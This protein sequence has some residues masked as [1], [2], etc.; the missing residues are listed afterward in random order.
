MD[1]RLHVFHFPSPERLGHLDD[2]DAQLGGKLPAAMAR[3]PFF[4]SLSAQDLGKQLGGFDAPIDVHASSAWG[5][6]TRLSKSSQR[7][8]LLVASQHIF[9]SN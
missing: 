9:N 5:E 7:L 2:V 6:I 1:A 3:W 4:I 8:N